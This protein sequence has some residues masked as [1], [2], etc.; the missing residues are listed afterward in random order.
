M[1]LRIGEKAPDFEADTTQGK[2]SCTSGWAIP[3][4]CCSPTQDFTPVCTTEL[5]YLAKLQPEF[6]KRNTKIIGLSVDP[7]GDHGRWWAT[8]K[9]P[10]AFSPITA[11]RRQRSQGRQALR[12]CCPPTPA[13]VAGPHRATN[14]TVRTVFLIGPD[15]LIKAMLVYPMSSGRN[16]TRCCVCST[17]PAHRETQGRDAGEL[18]RTAKTSSSCPRCPTKTRARSSPTAG[19]SQA[20]PAYRP[21][22]QR[23][24]RRAS[25]QPRPT[26]SSK[27]SRRSVSPR[28]EVALAWFIAANRCVCSRS[29]RSGRRSRRRMK[30]ATAP[31]LI[32]VGPALDRVADRRV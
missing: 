32:E 11:H 29:R 3:G 6:V 20:L 30:Y 12:T 26:R 4:A 13:S 1:S 31:A 25:R 10:P 22:A 2:I 23:L 24:G 19:S 14:Q 21:P 27:R 5:G 18:E 28:S 15:K 8:S 7:V 16:S 17:V 9:R